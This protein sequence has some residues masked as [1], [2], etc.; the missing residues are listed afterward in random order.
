MNSRAA[1]GQKALMLKADHGFAL[2]VREMHL[3]RQD[4]RNYIALRRRAHLKLTRDIVLGQAFHKLLLQERKGVC[5]DFTADGLWGFKPLA[6]FSPDEISH[7]TPADM[8]R[9][10]RMLHNFW[11]SKDISELFF[12]SCTYKNC[13][14][15]FIEKF[16]GCECFFSADFIMPDKGCVV[17][18]KTCRDTSPEGISGEIRRLQY[19]WQAWWAATGASISFEKPI[20]DFVFVFV[21]QNAP[22]EVKVYHAPM[23]MLNSAREELLPFIGMYGNFFETGCFTPR[24]AAK[25]RDL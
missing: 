8:W 3:F 10:E 11:H 9:L 2:G 16:T 22:F 23:G 1:I 13:G 18:V 20:T 5:I 6:D 15:L 25:M 7:V 24:T 14:G 12:N 19:H 17:D 4:P 21:G